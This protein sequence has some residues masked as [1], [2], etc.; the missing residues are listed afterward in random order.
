MKAVVICTQR[1][2]DSFKCEV[3]CYFQVLSSEINHRP[4]IRFGIRFRDTFFVPLEYVREVLK[5]IS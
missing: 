3:R 1:L 4:N 2:I 5:R